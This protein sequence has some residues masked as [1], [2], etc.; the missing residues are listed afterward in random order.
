MWIYYWL[1]ATDGML[2]DAWKYQS[3]HVMIYSL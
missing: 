1:F 3:C 2:Y